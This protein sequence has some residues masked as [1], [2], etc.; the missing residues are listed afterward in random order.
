MDT[1][2]A[3]PGP[4][5]CE[6]EY[7]GRTMNNDKAITVAICGSKKVVAEM[8]DCSKSLESMGMAS[9]LPTLNEPIDYATLPESDRAAT[10]SKLIRSHIEKIHA[11]DAVLICNVTLGDRV[12]YIGANSFLE[13][14]FAFAAG[15]PIYLFTDIPNQPNTDEIAG[16]LPI[17]LNGNLELIQH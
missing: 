13:M 2:F 14:G 5:P 4:K 7:A 12:N 17:C 16:M 6:R 11:S 8:N 1:L 3:F 10:K 15:K 9:H